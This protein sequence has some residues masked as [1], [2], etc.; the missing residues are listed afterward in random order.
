MLKKSVTPQDVCDLLNEY[1]KEDPQSCNSLFN[2]RVICNEK[3]AGHPT[4]QVQQYHKDEHPTIG[5]LGLL[6]GLFGIHESG[7]GAICILI[8][9]DKKIESFD[10]VE[11]YQGN[12]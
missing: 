11:N 1:L 4:I 10:L 6:N 7:M 8:G 9:D 5:L 12:L 2:H 3:I